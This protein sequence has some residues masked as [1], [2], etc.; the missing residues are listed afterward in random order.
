MTPPAATSK[1]AAQPGAELPQPRPFTFEKYGADE[2]GTDNRYELVQEYLRLMS[3]LAGLYIVIC[4]FL[5][6]VFNRFF[7]R[8]ISKVLPQLELTVD[9]VL[10]PPAVADLMALEQAENDAIATERDALK[11]ERD[12][13]EAEKAAM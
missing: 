8:I 10:D 5:V 4:E 13:I 12:T 3:P 2:D 6:Y 7:E 11:A 1:T 9:A